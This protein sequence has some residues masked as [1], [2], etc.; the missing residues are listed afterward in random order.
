M[1]LIRRLLDSER[2]CLHGAVLVALLACVSIVFLNG[3]IDS[4]VPGDVLAD[5]TNPADT[6]NPG[7][8]P[9]D[10]SNPDLTGPGTCDKP[11]VRLLRLNPWQGSGVQL[12]VEW[13]PQAGGDFPTDL[14]MRP[15]S[16]GA[17]VDGAPVQSFTISSVAAPQQAGLTGILIVPSADPAIHAQ[18]LAAAQ[19]VIDGLPTGERIALWLAR[20][21]KA[22]ML[23]S[24]LTEDRAHLTM[25][26]D[27]ILPTTGTS[28]PDPEV[29]ES[30]IDKLRERL[31]EAEGRWGLLWKSLIIV[32]ESSAARITADKA[33]AIATYYLV[34]SN[35]AATPDTFVVVPAGSAAAA[36]ALIID[37]KARRA[38]VY[39]LGA[40]PSAI[41]NQ[42][43]TL[44]LGDVTCTFE[45][46]V[47]AANLL[48]EACV[49][50]DAAADNFDYGDTITLVMTDV[51]K[52]VWDK[53]HA[54]RSKDDF[55]LSVRLGQGTAMPAT[56][57]FRGQSSLDCKRKSYD[58]NL[59]GGSSRRMMP[60]G[61]GDKF[62][63]VS[64]CLDDGY[65]NQVFVNTILGEWGVFP[66]KFRLVRL[67][68]NDENHGLYMLLQDPTDTLVKNHTSLDGVVRR[69]F[70]PDPR[71]VPDVK[72][73]GDDTVETTLAYYQDMVKIATD[74]PVETLLADMSKQ[75]DVQLY[76]RW[77]A[78]MTFLGSGD[79]VD[80]LF[81]YGTVE[82]DSVPWWRP[83]NWDAD[84]LFATCHHG[85]VKAIP[86]PNGMMY[87]AEGF[88]DQ[89]QIRSPEVYAAWVGQ[90]EWVMGQLSEAKAESVM[91]GIRDQLFALLDD[92]TA[93]A[94]VEFKTNHP[95]AIDA[96]ATK[97][98]IQTL[99][100][101][102]LNDIADSRN[103]LTNKIATW[104][105]ANP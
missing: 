12:Y 57:H 55:R 20:T 51:E 19:A 101:H 81:F 77:S 82:N 5:G 18:R 30:S 9:T 96:E 32:S 24:D 66:L 84:D 37:I 40:C 83:M 105:D 69:V 87:C 34:A 97:A 23:L 35:P 3:C 41:E 56:A 6:I 48:E 70:D 13:A 67:R 27:E 11:G 62:Y 71:L 61:G 80:E 60:G 46:P 93:A 75:L 26:L 89:A 91:Y 94:C 28:T 14:L 2:L 79:Y 52:S 68:L 7:D 8:V 39:R 86:D 10:T 22:P 73:F 21:G 33:P 45:A 103:N 1:A 92:E 76:F 65:F 53:R 44:L 72:Y 4:G 95:T 16:D 25:R 88:L 36:D 58:V 90:L 47:P 85:G 17:P 63:L 15:T 50:A 99:M 102:T 59:D 38:A 64:M 31:A 43:L 42:P 49:D 29:S 100:D 98:L 104:K 54:A 78:T 74:G